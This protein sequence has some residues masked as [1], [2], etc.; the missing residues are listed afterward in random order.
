MIES[1]IEANK[2]VPRRFLDIHHFREER[3]GLGDDETPRLKSH[4][5]VAVV[6]LTELGK[7]V[8]HCLSQLR[9]IERFL[10]GM[11]GNTKS[12]TK[13]H[14]LQ[15]RKVFCRPEKQVHRLDESCRRK[16]TR[17]DVLLKAHDGEL[18]F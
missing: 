14:V 4:L 6:L 10:V 1:R 15:V 13:I 3:T 8:R 12:S 9:D 17:T 11:V 7:G 2:C 16:N 18:V 5:E